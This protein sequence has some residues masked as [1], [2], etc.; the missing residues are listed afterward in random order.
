MKQ[1]CSVLFID[2]RYFTMMKS[3]IKREV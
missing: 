1:K 2:F 3:N